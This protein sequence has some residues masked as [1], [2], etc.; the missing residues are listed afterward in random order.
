MRAQQLGRAF[1]VPTGTTAAEKCDHE[2]VGTFMHQQVTAIVVGRLVAQPHLGIDRDP[3]LKFFM[4]RRQQAERREAPPVGYEKSARLPVGCLCRIDSEIS[5]PLRDRFVEIGRQPVDSL[6]TGR[7][8]IKHQ[9]LTSQF[10]NPGRLRACLVNRLIWFGKRLLRDE[11]KQNST[12]KKSGKLPM[13]QVHDLAA[14]RS[15]MASQGRAGM[16]KIF[17][18]PIRPVRATSTIFRATSSA[19]RSSTQT[20]ISTFGRNVSEYSVSAYRSR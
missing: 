16:M 4:A 6:A 3:V 20:V 13:W 12:K 18:S 15:I 10:A 5:R 8:G 2:R 9:V 17:P 1:H 11:A 7:I 19:R 14:A